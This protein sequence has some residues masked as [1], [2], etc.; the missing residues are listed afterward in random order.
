MSTTQKTDEKNALVTGASGSIGQAIVEMLLKDGWQV[1]G[2]GRREELPPLDESFVSSRFHYRSI[3]L[4]DEDAMRRV[5]AFVSGVPICLIINNAGCAYY[6][7]HEQ[8]RDEQIDAMVR[9]DLEVPM[10]ISRRYVS[11]LAQR[12]G[13]LINISSAC[14]LGPAVKGAVYGA[15]KAG[16]LQ[17]SRSL[18]EE[19]R[20]SGLRVSCILPDLTAGELY[21]NADFE[22]AVGSLMPSDVADAVH[23]VLHAREGSVVKCIEL[24]PQM[25]QIVKKK[26][27]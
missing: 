2:T 24:Q 17:F 12:H 13:W 11:A 5:D 22:P 20:K 4:L 1:Y 15:C 7:M 19:Y 21:R 27:L 18:F 26:A 3:D 25:A 23:T 6:G 16:L 14:A 8:I 10:L 9:V